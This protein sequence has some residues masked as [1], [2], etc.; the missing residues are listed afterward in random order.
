M[1]EPDRNPEKVGMNPGGDLFCLTQLL[2]RCCS[3]L[4]DQGPGI[5]HICQMAYQGEFF[6]QAAVNLFIALQNTR[7][8]PAETITEVFECQR[9]IWIVRQSRISNL[10]NL[11]MLLQVSGQRKRVFALTIH[12]Q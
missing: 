10:F 8:Y 2:M 9:M 1:L 12:T 5:T 6:N 7:Q 3:R 4:N 11:F